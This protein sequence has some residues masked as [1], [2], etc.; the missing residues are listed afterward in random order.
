[1]KKKINVLLALG[2]LGLAATAYS[3]CY[4]NQVVLCAKSGDKVA[5]SYMHTGNG[6]ASYYTD[7][8]ADEDCWRYDKY[9]VTRGGRGAQTGNNYVSQCVGIATGG[10]GTS[11]GNGPMTY[12]ADY[13]GFRVK[14]W[15][16]VVGQNRTAWNGGANT[17]PPS[18]AEMFDAYHVTASYVDNALANTCN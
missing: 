5:G 7:V 1:M 17:I 11:G 13:S 15:D 6:E 10:V 18:G 2:L 8:F 3:T 12:Q 16:S 4:L 9:S 14:Y